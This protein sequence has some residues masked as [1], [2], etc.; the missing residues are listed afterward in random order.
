MAVVRLPEAS[1]RPSRPRSCASTSRTTPSSRPTPCSGPWRAAEVAGPTGVYD[2]IHGDDRVAATGAGREL[3]E[4]QALVTAQED[5]VDVRLATTTDQALAI[6]DGYPSPVRL[7]A[8][9][10][11]RDDD[12]AVRHAGSRPAMLATA[13]LS[14]S[15][16]DEFSMFHE[17]A[18]EF[19]LPYD[20]PPVVRREAV[21]LGDGRQLERAGVGRRRRPSW[22]CCT[23]A[24][25]TPTRGTRSRWRSAVRWWPSTCPATATPTA[26][27]TRSRSTPGA[28]RRRRRRRPSA[29]SRPSAAR[30]RRHV[31]RRHDG[32]RAR[33]RRTPSSC[34]GSCS[35]TSRPGVDRRQGRG[36]HRLRRRARELPQLRRPPGPHGRVQPDPDA[37]R[38]CG[39]ASSTTPSSATTARWVWRYARH[40]HRQPRRRRGRDRRRHRQP[41]SGTSSRRLDRAR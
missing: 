1:S 39:G 40:A 2:L 19:G 22:S 41:L 30:G 28:E 32:A 38:R 7:S 36:D 20:G 37:C 4:L 34:A 29:R 24:R 10:E 31:A 33:G 6:D 15:P 27:R 21:D 25:R 12:G 18:E 8:T 3:S 23:A 17:N 35:S 13:W 16:Y 11:P 26:R 14:V 5:L 9:P